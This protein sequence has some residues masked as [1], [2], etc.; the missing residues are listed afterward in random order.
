VTSGADDAGA[1]ASEPVRT[2]E[3]ELAFDADEA[4]PLPEWDDVPAV[5]SVGEPE[6]RELDG[7]YFDTA[8]LTLARGGVAIRRRTGGPDEGWHLK[9]PKIAGAREE[10]QWPLSAADIPDPVI[11]AASAWTA[12]PLVPIA[13]IRNTRTAYALRDAS[14]TTIAEFVDDRVRAR[15]ELTGT[16]RAWRE[17]ELELAAAAPASAEWRAEFFAAAERAIR[18]AGARPAASASK[19]ARTLGH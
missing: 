11:E 1:R 18:A 2:V 16:E 7:R 19:L 17:W 8:D 10:L 9:G 5:A 4:T 13:R 15:D 3:I 14:G 12:E 6:V